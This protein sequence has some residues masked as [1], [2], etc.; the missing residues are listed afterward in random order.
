MHFYRRFGLV[1]EL[2]GEWTLNG[3]YFCQNWGSS[4]P[5]LSQYLRGLPEF[6]ELIAPAVRK[7]FLLGFTEL[8][9]LDARAGSCI[10]FYKSPYGKHI[11]CVDIIDIHD[12]YALNFP[13]CEPQMRLGDASMHI[14]FILPSG[15]VNHDSFDVFRAKNP[16]YGV[17]QKIFD[18][19]L[20]AIG[21]YL[22]GPVAEEVAAEFDPIYIP[23][24]ILI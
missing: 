13:P 8:G 22:P 15:R 14:F 23:A 2:T 3:N 11:A 18:P 24:V 19:F 16:E 6:R 4:N 20:I 5:D 12:L 7:V 9:F 17:V 21:E 10:V 1:H